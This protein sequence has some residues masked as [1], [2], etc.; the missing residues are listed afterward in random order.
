MVP[1]IFSKQCCSCRKVVF[2]DEE[3][4]EATVNITGRGRVQPASPYHDSSE[5]EPEHI[6]VYRHICCYSNQVLPIDYDRVSA[7]VFRPFEPYSIIA[8]SFASSSDKGPTLVN[9]AGTSEES[10]HQL[11]PYAHMKAQQQEEIT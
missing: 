10:A 8:E 9:M 6:G 1:T 4:S 3:Y 11:E 7:G 5:N 2:F